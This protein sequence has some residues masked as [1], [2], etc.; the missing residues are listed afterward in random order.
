MLKSSY[1]C[2]ECQKY[3]LFDEPDL[4]VEDAMEMNES[5]MPEKTCPDCN[6]RMLFDEVFQ[7]NLN[8]NDNMEDGADV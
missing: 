3:H 7:G 4:T 2:D 8:G 6:K 5:D 1:W